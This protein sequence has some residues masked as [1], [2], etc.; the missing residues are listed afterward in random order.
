MILWE[1]GG[2][3][4]RYLFSG[5]FYTEEEWSHPRRVIDSYEALYVQSGE[6]YLEEEGAPYTL[7]V[8]QGFLLRPGC[9]H[10]G[11]KTSR[12]KTAFYWAHFS[13][14]DFTALRLQPGFFA[15]PEPHRLSAGFR[16]LLH[17]A[18][19]VNYPAYAADAAMAS[20]LAELYAVQRRDGAPGM[21]LVCDTAE[22]VRINSGRKLS[23]AMVADQAGYHPDYLC[24]VFR[25]E[26]G[27]SLKRYINEERMKVAKNRLLTTELSV[28]ELAGE[29]G[30]ENENAFIHYFTYHEGI[31]PAHYRNLYFHTH[32]NNR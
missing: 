30:W 28:K 9:V 27:K 16:R 5:K 11:W 4:L 18:N 17:V 2:P 12:G 1:E 8:Q 26:T 23:V 22:W 15:P 32:M 19:A 7:G 21:R 10:G 3:S 24:A 29:L 31:S 25:R 14:S 20:L 6:V 13:V